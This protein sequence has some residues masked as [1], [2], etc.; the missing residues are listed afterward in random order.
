MDADAT[1]IRPD[2]TSMGADATATVSGSFESKSMEDSVG[3]GS[4]DPETEGSESCRRRGAE[5]NSDPDRSNPMQA[6]AT[7]SDESAAVTHML[8][9][10]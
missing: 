10:R 4:G 9:Y 3:P 6:A 8:A 2:A 7:E 1:A 5:S